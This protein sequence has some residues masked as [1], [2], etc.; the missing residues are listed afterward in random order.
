LLTANLIFSFLPKVQTFGVSFLV[1]AL[2][3]IVYG[4]EVR[5]TNFKKVSAVNRPV[6]TILAKQK[7]RNAARAAEEEADDLCPNSSS[8]FRPG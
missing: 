1:I 2:L 6:K 7:G 3:T 5:E 8:V 4:P